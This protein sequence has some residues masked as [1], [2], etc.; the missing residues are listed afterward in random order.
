[1]NALPDGDFSFVV[2]TG[3]TL[4]FN[5]STRGILSMGIYQTGTA[6]G[7]GGGGMGAAINDDGAV[8]TVLSLG[9]QDY[10]ARVYR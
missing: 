2:K 6:P 7:G 9:G 8:F 1:M 5:G 3:Q 4:T 10:V